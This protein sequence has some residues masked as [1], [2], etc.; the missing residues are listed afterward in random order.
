MRHSFSEKAALSFF[1]F[2]FVQTCITSIKCSNITSAILPH[3][4]RAHT[5]ALLAITW[6]I[7]A[8]VFTLIFRHCQFHLNSQFRRLLVCLLFCDF[9]LSDSVNDQQQKTKTPLS[10]AVSLGAQCNLTL[11]FIN[12]LILRTARVVVFLAHCLSFLFIFCYASFVQLPCLHP[13][14]ELPRDLLAPTV[15]LTE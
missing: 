5:L 9:C 15:R 6:L 1:Y 4:T 3:T 12:K 11:D 14:D 2:Y 13:K 10:L 7:D 8:S